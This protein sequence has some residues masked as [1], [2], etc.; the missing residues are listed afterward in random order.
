M[1]ALSE[2]IYLITSTFLRTANTLKFHSSKDKRQATNIVLPQFMDQGFKRTGL[3]DVQAPEQSASA[4]VFMYQRNVILKSK[5]LAALRNAVAP[6]FANICFS[7][8][9]RVG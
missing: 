1:A 5:V 4:D 9:P 2:D 6:E 7:L 3:P 8:S